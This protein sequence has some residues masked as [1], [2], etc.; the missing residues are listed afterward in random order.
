MNAGDINRVF[1][2]DKNLA[3]GVTNSFSGLTITGGADST[4]GGAG[5]IGGSDNNTTSDSLTLTNVVVSKE[6]GQR[7]EPDRDEQAGRRRTVLRRPTR[8]LPTRRSATTPP[9]RARL[10]GR[11]RG[12]RTGVARGPDHHRTDVQRQQ[13]RQFNGERATTVGGA[14]RSLR[15]RRHQLRVSELPLREQHG[16]RPRVPDRPSAARSTRCRAAT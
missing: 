1:D 16:D 7:R 8:R 2:L 5:I 6:R 4:F 11:V 13:R 10:G 3:G 12:E 14:L 15:H 9:V